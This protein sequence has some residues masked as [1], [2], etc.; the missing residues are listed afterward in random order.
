[1][2]LPVYDEDW[3]CD[4]EQLLMPLIL[5]GV[6]VFMRSTS[7]RGWMNVI[8]QTR[9]YCLLMYISLYRSALHPP[10]LE[11][12]KES[13][14]R[15]HTTPQQWRPVWSERG[16]T[17][18]ADRM[19]EMADLRDNIYIVVAVRSRRQLDIAKGSYSCPL[20]TRPCPSNVSSIFSFFYF[21]EDDAALATGR[22]GEKRGF[23]G[24][25]SCLLYTSCFVKC[26]VHSRSDCLWTTSPSVLPCAT[27]SPSLFSGCAEGSAYS[28]LIPN[29]STAVVG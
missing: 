14:S 16:L 29:L 3:I 13:F 18:D 1:M 10:I 25:V 20:Q 26:V 23:D 2:T 27:T 9:P 24:F 11:E 15:K 21:V 28:L 19:A 12:P 8:N 5:F 4:C 22:T 6:F 17:P 7:G